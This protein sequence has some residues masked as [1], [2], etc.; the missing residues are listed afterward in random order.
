MQEA[1]TFPTSSSVVLHRSE[2][3]LREL[4]LGPPVGGV[5]KLPSNHIQCCDWRGARPHLE[6]I[7]ADATP[8]QG[9]MGVDGVETGVEKLSQESC[10]RSATQLRSPIRPG[11][12]V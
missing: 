1:D 8:A 6:L 2:K 7:A 4:S 5:S 12:P 11:S 10:L 9:E 3:R